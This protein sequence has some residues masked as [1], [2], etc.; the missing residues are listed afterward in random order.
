MSS[1][2]TGKAFAIEDCLYPYL[3]WP[4][5]IIVV[6]AEENLP[7]NQESRGYIGLLAN[8]HSSVRAWDL[9][10]SST[11]C[12]FCFSW[13]CRAVLQKK[14]FLS[15]LLDVQCRNKR[16]PQLQNKSWVVQ[17]SPS[18]MYGFVDWENTLKLSAAQP[19][20]SS[21]PS[22]FLLTVSLFPWCF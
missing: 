14:C 1:K 2:N 5:Q 12:C 7:W 16:H 9:G 3:W 8:D 18:S 4:T 6:F 22:H 13:C 21:L 15:I 11:S 20:W 10:S 19:F 17:G